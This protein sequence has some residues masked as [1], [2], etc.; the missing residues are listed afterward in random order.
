VTTDWTCVLFDLDGTI[1]DSAPGI[2]AS[3]AWT[4]EQ[5]GLPIPSPTELLAYVG[6]PILESFRERAGMTHDEAEHALAT[7]RPHYAKVG[8]L[9][10]TVHSGV[11]EL[12]E[13]IGESP[14]PLSLATSKPESLATTALT[15]FGLA[16]YFDFF[17]GASEDEVRS[18]KADVV[19]EAL[20]RL[21]QAGFDISRPVL[22]GDRHHDVDGGAEHGVPT[23]FVTWGYGSPAEQVGAVAVA[24]SAAE[25]E[26]LILG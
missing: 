13:R 5:L 21:E 9:D 11:A 2:T 19:A 22:V 17:T 24:S 18:S 12:V 25:V 14:L 8:V 16:K 1:L 3:L 20:R 10:A 6:P 4:F 26:K 7:Y 23:I 15:H